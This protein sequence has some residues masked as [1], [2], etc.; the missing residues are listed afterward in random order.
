MELLAFALAIVLA[1]WFTR[2]LRQS[3]YPRFAVEILGLALVAG[4]VG[5]GAFGAWYNSTHANMGVPE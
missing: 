3:W 4:V 5:V 1:W 2:N